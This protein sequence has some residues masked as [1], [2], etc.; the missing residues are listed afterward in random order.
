M[1]RAARYQGSSLASM[2]KVDPDAPRIPVFAGT[3]GT[4]IY[5]SKS[6]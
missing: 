3:S 2:A 4:G 5:A 6:V 1:M